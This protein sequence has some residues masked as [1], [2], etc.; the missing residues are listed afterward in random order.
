M[1]ADVQYQFIHVSDSRVL[2]VVTVMAN[3]LPAAHAAVI[4]QIRSRR[5]AKIPLKADDYWILIELVSRIF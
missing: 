2:Q 5:I 3:C 1:A 4:F